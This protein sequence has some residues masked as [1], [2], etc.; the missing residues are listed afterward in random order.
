[1]Y[2]IVCFF[3]N[4][5]CSSL[6]DFPKDHFIQQ[7]SFST[8]RQSVYSSDYYCDIS[9]IFISAN[10]PFAYHF[11]Q[12]H[13]PNANINL[14]ELQLQKHLFLVRVQFDATTTTA[15]RGAL[16]GPEFSKLIKVTQGSAWSKH[17]EFFAA[18]RHAFEGDVFSSLKGWLE[19]QL[20]NESFGALEF[21]YG[22]TGYSM[23]RILKWEEVN[24]QLKYLM[25]HIDCVCAAIEA[26][27][28]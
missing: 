6:I 22:I 4:V 11:S 16:Q 10:L 2:C 8:P 14:L 17:R 20:P 18:Q 15:S 21:R 5:F 19:Y 13:S 9:T 7:V 25:T 26:C 1:M 3:C 28:R 24:S 27:L 23:C 12:Q